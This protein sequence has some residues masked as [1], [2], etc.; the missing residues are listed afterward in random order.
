[1]HDTLLTMMGIWA[2]VKV[3]QTIK[4]IWEHLGYQNETRLREQIRDLKK[5]LA[6]LK[7]EPE[8][9]TFTLLD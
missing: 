7:G 8:E 3:M 1:M 5:E 4:E 6:A 2:A 9:K